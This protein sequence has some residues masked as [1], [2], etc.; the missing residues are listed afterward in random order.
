MMHLV[1]NQSIPASLMNSG[2]PADWQIDGNLGGTAALA[3]ALLQSHEMVYANGSLLLAQ[4]GEVGKVPLIR[5]LPAL[6]SSWAKVGGGGFVTGLRARG[7]FT[8]GLRWDGEGML[9]DA[10]ITSDHDGEAYVTLG[11]TIL[12]S[13]NGTML[14][15][16][17][18]TDAVFLKLTTQAGCESIVTP[19]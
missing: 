17:G 10:T 5:I 13:N 19:V 3:E 11:Q 16:A 9:I 12:G 4:T 8:V 14:K 2:A 15:S 7:G 18:A 1:A 6:P